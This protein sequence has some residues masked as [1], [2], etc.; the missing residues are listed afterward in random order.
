MSKLTIALSFIL[1]A[2]CA[3]TSG[4]R[5]L[6]IDGTNESTFQ[7]SVASIQQ[8]LPRTRRAQFD[9]ALTD[10]WINGAIDANAEG[11]DE[12]TP[13]EY[14]AQLHGLGYVDV[15]SLA[16]SDPLRETYSFARRAPSGPRENPF[17]PST[18]GR[19]GWGSSQIDAFDP[20]PTGWRPT[21]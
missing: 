16:D 5:A 18:A 12:F 4:W 8:E 6:R 1:L 7:A 13:G 11:S 10:I 19:Y 9:L 3:G 17:P 15:V 14:F 20:S 2:G 21:P